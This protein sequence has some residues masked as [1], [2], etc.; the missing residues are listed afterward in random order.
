MDISAVRVSKING[1]EFEGMED[2]IIQQ[3]VDTFATS[4]KIRD[5][6]DLKLR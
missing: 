5:D 6:M 4:R 3:V 1:W 2:F